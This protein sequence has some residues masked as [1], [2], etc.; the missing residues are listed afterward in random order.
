M[1]S[2]SP[3]NTYRHDQYVVNS[4]PINGP[5]ATAIAPPAITMP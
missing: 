1:T 2:T 5:M 3:T 4:P